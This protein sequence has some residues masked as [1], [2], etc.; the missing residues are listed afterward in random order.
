[1]LCFKKNFLITLSNVEGRTYTCG[2]I[3]TGSGSDFKEKLDPDPTLE[4]YPGPSREKK[5]DPG[6]EV[7]PNEQNYMLPYLYTQKQ[8]CESL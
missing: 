1:M 2:F 3:L 8:S 7:D 6:P 4:K 5:H